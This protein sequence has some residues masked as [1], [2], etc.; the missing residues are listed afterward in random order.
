MYIYCC[1]GY[2]VHVRGPGGGE[3]AGGHGGGVPGP[4]QPRLRILQQGE[5]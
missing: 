2:R 4:R 5:L 3:E 1:L